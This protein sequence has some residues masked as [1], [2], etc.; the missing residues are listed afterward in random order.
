MRHLLQGYDVAV[1]QAHGGDWLFLSVA[2]LLNLRHADLRHPTCNKISPV[3]MNC[4]VVLTAELSTVTEALVTMHCSQK[5]Q[6][7]CSALHHCP[8][9]ARPLNA[10]P[11]FNLASCA[12]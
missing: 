12:R 4:T 5:Y 1:L 10:A 3:V 9:H 6:T 2:A 11:C 8:G 7:D